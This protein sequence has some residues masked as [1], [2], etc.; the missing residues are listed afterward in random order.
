MKYIAGYKIS[1][2]V[3]TFWT[4]GDGCCSKWDDNDDY[5]EVAPGDVIEINKEQFGEDTYEIGSDYEG[6]SEYH[7][8]PFP[9]FD[10]SEFGLDEV[11]EAQID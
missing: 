4:C 11:E 1:I 8:R 9:D 3:M 10:P 2:P 5:V 6:I 7:Y